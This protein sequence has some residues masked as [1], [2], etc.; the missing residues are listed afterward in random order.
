MLCL[1][2]MMPPKQESVSLATIKTNANLVTP[3][4][5]LGLEDGMTTPTRVETKQVNDQIMGTSI[6]R[7]WDT[8]LCS[9]SWQLIQQHESLHLPTNQ[10]SFSGSKACASTLIFDPENET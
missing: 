10:I 9:E 5:G 2:T 6:S 1:A 3:E 4:S 8:S 7:Q